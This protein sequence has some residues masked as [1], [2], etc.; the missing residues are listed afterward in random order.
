MVDLPSG[1]PS[2]IYNYGKIHHA[3]LMANSTIFMMIFHS[4][5][6]VYQRVSSINPINIP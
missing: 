2:H 3:F 1:K 4:F 6:Y 5:L